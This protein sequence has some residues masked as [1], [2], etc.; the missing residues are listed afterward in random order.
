V[1]VTGYTLGGGPGWLARRHGL[2]ANSVT[3]AELITPDGRW[4]TRRESP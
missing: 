4:N 1:E 3:G 2:A